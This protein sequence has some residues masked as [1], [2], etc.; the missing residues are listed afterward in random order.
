M[1]EEDLAVFFDAEELAETITVEGVELVGFLTEN[2]KTP[3][4]SDQYGVFIEK[5]VLSIK[6]ENWQELGS[7]SFGYT[8]HVNEIENCSVLD[9]LFIPVEKY[10]ELLPE[11]E[12]KNSKYENFRKEVK[13]N[14]N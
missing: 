5:K 11:I 14:V 1:L 3:S 4:K 7:P 12:S 2:K 6:K 8:L 10:P 9:K 13:A